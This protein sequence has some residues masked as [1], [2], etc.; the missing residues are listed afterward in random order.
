[1][2]TLTF[3]IAAVACLLLMSGGGATLA[4]EAPSSMGLSFGAH[5]FSS[6]TPA[7]ESFGSDL[8]YGGSVT[9]N[10]SNHLGF[11]TSYDYMKGEEADVDV[12]SLNVY[13]K[14]GIMKPGK[15]FAIS[16]LG[17]L[18]WRAPDFGDFQFDDPEFAFG[19]HVK[20]DFT[21]KVG[22]YITATTTLKDGYGF[23]E[24]ELPEPELFDYWKVRGGLA[25]GI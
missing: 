24:L 11:Y 6:E 19:G 15:S 7:P 1:M 23:K 4:Q 3:I 25:Y 10:V 14:L 13:L 9:Y 20:L 21:T 18:E 22:A 17:G 2:R 12:Q 5:T 8:G 16:A